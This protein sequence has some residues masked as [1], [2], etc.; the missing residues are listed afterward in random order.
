MSTTER[1]VSQLRTREFAGYTLAFSE[2]EV[3]GDDSGGPGELFGRIVPYDTPT[4]I[5]RDVVEVFEKG[6]L[7]KTL[8]EN[9]KGV[10]LFSTHET[11]SRQ[12]IGSVKDFDSR[13]DGMYVRF[14]LNRTTDA[15]DVRELVRTGDATGLSVGFY[16]VRSFDRENDGVTTIIRKE[17]KLDH[18]AVVH[19]PAYPD[20]QVAKAR[21]ET[22]IEPEAV[23]EESRRDRGDAEPDTPDLDRWLE[24]FPIG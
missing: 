20:A 3:R 23:P 15:N 8:S 14:S 24:E 11:R 1:H 10:K 16:P 6:S 18:V 5:G 7:D 9:S 13:D 12:P 19:R 21:A 17:A 2:C 22:E 4:P